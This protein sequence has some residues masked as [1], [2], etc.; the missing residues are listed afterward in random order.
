MQGDYCKVVQRGTNYPT[1][2]AF[3]SVNTPRGRFKPYRIVAETPNVNIIFVNDCGN[4]WYQHGIPG[5]G[6]SAAEAAKQLAL[7]ARR[8]GNGRVI[9]FGTSMGAFG[10]VLY[11]ALG[12]ADGCMVFGVE[13]PLNL[14]ASRSRLYMPPDLLLPFP[15]LA[16]ILEQSGV[17]TL[18]YASE[19]DEVDLVSLASLAHL[20]NVTAISIRGMDHPGVQIFDLDR[21]IQG[22]IS[23]FAQQGTI[24]DGFSRQGWI[25][26]QSDLIARLWDAYQVKAAKER[27]K[28]L[29]RAQSI[30]KL[31][32]NS[33]TAHLRLGEAHYANSDGPSA[34][35]AW[36]TAI[37]ICPYQFEAMTKLGN[38]LRRHKKISEA[39][40]L[41]MRGI[42]INPW[43]AHGHHSLGEVYAE[44]GQFDKAEQHLREA[45][46]LNR[47]NISFKRSLGEFLTR[48]AETK[49]SEADN[50]LASIG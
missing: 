35:A 7:E 31:W 3:S 16:P 5:V 17:P 49:K 32:P 8:I 28:W 18:I 34:E 15:A 46:S 42:E 40:P 11:A 41:L 47:G 2:I 27:S 4:R 9:T 19:T 25:L 24:P 30:A 10:A 20:S 37:S 44:T 50:L 39:M 38:Y 21:S 29:E 26:Q 22:R 12:M 6:D 43:N 23:T 33:A 36:R 45:I 13:S 48:L 1:V 14:P